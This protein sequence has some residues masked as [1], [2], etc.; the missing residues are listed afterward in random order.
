MNN[1]NNNDNIHNNKYVND[2]KR[3]N[4]SIISDAF[5]GFYQYNN[6]LNS[7]NNS[8]NSPNKELKSFSFIKFNLNEISQFYDLINSNGMNL[9]HFYNNI[10]L[11]NCFDYTF[12][13]KTHSI[14]SFPKYLT[15]VLSQTDKCN[16]I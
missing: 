14:Y 16:F 12:K 1:I 6:L 15:I 8:F 2:F 10:N 9:N 3:Y 13:D 7:Q 11:Y 5:T 4:K